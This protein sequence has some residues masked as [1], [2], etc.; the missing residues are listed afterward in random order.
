MTSGKK[1][2]TSEV[3]VAAAG[4]TSRIL[5]QE[6]LN[7]QCTIDTNEP[8]WAKVDKHIFTTRS[9]ALLIAFEKIVLQQNHVS[10]VIAL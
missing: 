10:R 8:F 4:K 2:T 5:E 1:D 7:F 9:D 3:Y 6:G